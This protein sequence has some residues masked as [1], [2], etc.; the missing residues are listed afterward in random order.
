MTLRLIPLA[1]AAALLVS[2][3][4]G[5]AQSKP[6][7]GAEADPVVA[8]VNGVELHQSDV[9]AAQRSL[10]QQYR[11]APL[12][13][14]YPQLLDQLVT[15]ELVTE[16][17]QKA[18]FNDDPEVKKQTA[19]F[20]RRAMREAWLQHVVAE[21]ATDQRLHEQ[22]QKYLKDHPAR[23]EVKASHILV[24]NEGEAKSIIAQLDKGADFAALAK[25]HSSDSSKDSGGELGYFGKEDM[26]PEFSAA[27]FKLAKG[28]Y[29]ETPVKTQFGWHVIKVE[30]RRVAQPSFSEVKE[31][32]TDS[33]A[34]EAIGERIKQLR[35]GAKVQTFTLDGKPQP[36]LS[37]APDHP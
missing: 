23:E 12:A 28:Q 25:Q 3:P 19:E 1:T 6:A 4:A 37:L 31:E 5:M 16:A 35:A 27:A 20:E 7:A 29:T 22:Y 36:A 33:L 11:Q 17:A 18:K 14:I 24:A 15:T 9:L 32:L 34:R 21:T 30:D 2:A 13:Q 26:V 10:P 8:R